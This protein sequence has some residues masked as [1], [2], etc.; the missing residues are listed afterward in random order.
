MMISEVI[1]K[2]QLVE[3]EFTPSEACDVV[4]S[5]INEKIN[6]HNLQRLSL[7]EGNIHANLNYPSGRIEALYKEK[8]IAREIIDMAKAK[9]CKLKIN[10][11][12]EIELI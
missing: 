11:I 5:L 2:I 7:Y 10:G 4:C 3:G 6:F 12:L 9:G 1:Q 8:K